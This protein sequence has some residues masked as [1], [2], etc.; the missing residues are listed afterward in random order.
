[1]A[2]LTET[3]P[4]S[5]PMPAIAPHPGLSWSLLTKNP[6]VRDPES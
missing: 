5:H 1:M 2:G 6:P 4:L 3:L